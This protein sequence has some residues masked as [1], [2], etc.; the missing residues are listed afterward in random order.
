MI[1]QSSVIIH[2][3]QKRSKLVLHSVV[4]TMKQGL[5]REGHSDAGVRI[6]VPIIAYTEY[7]PSELFKTYLLN[8]AQSSEVYST[9]ARAVF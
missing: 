9:L 4:Y 1:P 6:D 8:Q 5:S 3:I 7:Q 2:D